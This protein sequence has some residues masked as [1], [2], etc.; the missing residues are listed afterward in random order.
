VIFVNEN[1]NEIV[2]TIVYIE[3]THN[4]QTQCYLVLS[5]VN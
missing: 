1:A 4:K 5:L 3:E 2:K